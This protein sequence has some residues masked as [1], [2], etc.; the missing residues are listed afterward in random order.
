MSSIT[1]SLIENA[2]AIADKLFT[3][4]FRYADLK[5]ATEDARIIQRDISMLARKA[6]ELST[7]DELTKE[8]L[9]K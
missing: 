2:E 3:N 7:G 5:L 1:E 4:D 6:A 9:K 8:N